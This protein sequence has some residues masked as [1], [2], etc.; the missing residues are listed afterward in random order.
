MQS[1]KHNDNNVDDSIVR[2]KD[3]IGSHKD[4]IIYLRNKMT[5]RKNLINSFIPKNHVQRTSIPIRLTEIKTATKTNC[6]LNFR[7]GTC[8]EQ[9]GSSLIFKQSIEWRFTVKLL[10]GVI[11]TYS[12]MHRTDK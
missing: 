5:E 1:N 12:Q 7:Y 9:G 6:H 11:I 2:L 4:E 8:F 3:Q 10:R